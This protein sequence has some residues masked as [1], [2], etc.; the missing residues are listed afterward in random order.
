[1][2]N[3][4]NTI[5]Q[6]IVVGLTVHH[7]DDATVRRASGGDGL[8]GASPTF[9]TTHELLFPRAVLRVQGNPTFVLDGIEVIVGDSEH[10]PRVSLADETRQVEMRR[11]LAAVMGQALPWRHATK[12]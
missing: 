10:L 9:G 4:Q 5:P 1:M 8:N 3:A 6:A 11:G 2:P 7:V 12:R